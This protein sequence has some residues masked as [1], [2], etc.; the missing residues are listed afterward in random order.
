MMAE[1]YEKF[2]KEKKRMGWVASTVSNWFSVITWQW[3]SWKLWTLMTAHNRK[4]DQ[5]ANLTGKECL[6]TGGGIKQEKS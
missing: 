1:V 5:A 4:M 3:P 6:I 2:Q